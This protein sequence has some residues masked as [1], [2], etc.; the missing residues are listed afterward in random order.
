MRKEMNIRHRCPAQVVHRC[1]RSMILGV[2]MLAATMSGTHAEDATS[3]KRFNVF[4]SVQDNHGQPLAGVSITVSTGNGSLRQTGAG[5]SM[6]D[7]TF[8]VNFGP[9]SWHLEL[10]PETGHYEVPT[11]VGRQA[12]T[13][14]ARKDGYY[15]TNLSRQ[16]G[17][18]M[19]ETLPESN[20]A[21]NTGPRK[22]VLP[23][24][25]FHLSF[26][27]APAAVVSGRLQSK[28]GEPLRETKVHLKGDELPPSQ[29]VLDS[30][31]TDDD[32][33]FSFANIPLKAFWFEAEGASTE[34]V[35]FSAPGVLAVVVAHTA[36]SA[37]ALTIESSRFT[38]SVK[39]NW[40]PEQA[41]GAP[42]TPE[43]GDKVTA[44]ASRTPDGHREW[45]RLTYASRITPVAV[46]IHETYNPGAVN[47]ITANTGD[48]EHV[49]WTGTDPTSENS[50]LGISEIPLNSGSDVETITL[51][52]DSPR[53]QG[54]NEIDAVGLLDG[55]G[56]VHWAQAAVAS[57]TYAEKPRRASAPPSG[58]VEP[59]LEPLD[60][61]ALAG[62]S[63]LSHVGN[64]YMGKRSL[65]GSG[66]IVRFDSSDGSV[67]R[68]VQIA[69]SRY[70]TS[71]PPDENFR[72]CLLDE[73]LQIIRALE[74]PY[75]LFERGNLRWY[76]L[77]IPEVAVPKTFHVALDFDPHRTKGIYLAHADS[78]SESHSFRGLPGGTL[79]PT[80]SGGEW[81]MRVY[82]AKE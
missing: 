31:L 22:T 25:P 80:K 59:D 1:S 37:P 78:D 11:T 41:T 81:M 44:W 32:G 54:W 30:A 5:T 73:S 64:T 3:T 29:N 4:G 33:R 6:P 10:N 68:A 15:E 49:L 52:L 45:L 79:Q 57:S 69:A 76:K 17:L 34:A 63:V 9:G 28:D 46:Q 21:D 62:L 60:T 75:A 70:G 38:P 55:A 56:N 24:E 27:M 61:T 40:G 72:L 12:A 53:V 35:Q 42:D 13:V 58:E 26:T 71:T 50:T 43:A 14:H 19:A 18:R 39:R 8:S 67:V 51:Y 77:K 20:S 2:T 16:G 65:G 74:Y 48:D 82:R 23:G 66:H 36:N 7:G 47:R